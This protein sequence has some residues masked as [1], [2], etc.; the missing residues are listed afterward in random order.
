MERRQWPG[1]FVVADDDRD[2]APEL[3]RAM[4]IEQVD[5]AVLVAGDEDRRPRPVGRILDAIVHPESIDERLKRGCKGGVADVE[6]FEVELHPHEETALLVV[7]VLGGIEDVRAVL[8]EEARDR[9]D[10][11]FRVWAIHK[12]NG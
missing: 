7:A 9:R 12:E 10:Q 5:E 8:E 11:A 6:S 4:A 2:V 3:A 1:I